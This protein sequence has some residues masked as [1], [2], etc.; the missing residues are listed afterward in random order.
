MKTGNL[1]SFLFIFNYFLVF[2]KFYFKKKVF[3]LIPK[4]RIGS[5]FEKN[6]TKSFITYELAKNQDAKKYIDKLAIL[7]HFHTQLP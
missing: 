5:P 4:Y 2:L 3:L 1:F 6:V 7:E